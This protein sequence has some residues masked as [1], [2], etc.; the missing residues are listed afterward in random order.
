MFKLTTGF[1]YRYFHL[2]KFYQLTQKEIVDLQVH[3][4]TR[5]QCHNILGYV[6]P[7]AKFTTIDKPQCCISR[8]KGNKFD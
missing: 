6:L 4:S 8:S 2:I 5:D 3:L 1:I 7:C